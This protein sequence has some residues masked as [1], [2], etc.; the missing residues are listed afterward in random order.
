[1]RARNVMRLDLPLVH[2]TES[3][4][5]AA[6]LMRRSGV[7]QLAVVNDGLLAGLLAKVD[8]E[9]FWGHEGWTAVA[10]AMSREPL[11]V[12]PDVHVADVARLLRDRGFDAVPVAVDGVALG[13]IGRRD[14][15]AAVVSSAGR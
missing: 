12:E 8:L 11:T 10:V 14:L 2:P 6:D 5:H 3:L 1:M 9:P 7:R 13:M 15:L 4:A